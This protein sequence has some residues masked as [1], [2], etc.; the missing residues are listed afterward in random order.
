RLFG[1]I[2]NVIKTVL[3]TLS[4]IDLSVVFDR[5]SNN[6]NNSNNNNDNNNN[7]VYLLSNTQKRSLPSS[8]IILCF[9]QISTIINHVLQRLLS[10]SEN[11][12]QYVFVCHCLSKTTKVS[13]NEQTKSVV[14]TYIRDLIV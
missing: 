12:I 7:F 2:L 5:S 10:N 14:F 3:K 13:S 6:H 8:S 4:D 1:F 9:T 11:N